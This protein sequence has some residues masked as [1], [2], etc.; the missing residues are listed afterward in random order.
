MHRARE[1]CAVRRL[2]EEV[3]VVG[4]DREVDD[5]EVVATEV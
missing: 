1:R 3:K 4:L 5:A 2:D